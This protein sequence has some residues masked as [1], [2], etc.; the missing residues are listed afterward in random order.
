M[1]ETPRIAQ[2]D[3]THETAQDAPGATIVTSGDLQVP[4]ISSL[5]EAHVFPA[6][7]FIASVLH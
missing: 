2:A 4:L 7:Q 5:A 6:A 1:S 3:A